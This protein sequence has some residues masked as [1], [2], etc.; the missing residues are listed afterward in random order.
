MK[1]NNI[2]LNKLNVFYQVV[3]LGGYAKASEHL[4]V[5]KSALSQSITSLETQIGVNLF[6]RRSKK[7]IPTREALVLF[8]SFDEHHKNLLNTIETVLCSKDSVSGQVRVG[9]YLEFAKKELSSFLASFLSENSDAQVKFKFESPSRLRELLEKNRLDL[10]FSIHPVKGVKGVSSERILK[11]E[12]VMICEKG[13]RSHFKNFE[14]FK[15]ARYIGYYNDH[16]VLKRW[17]GVHFS[18]RLRIFDVAVFAA[19]AE[20]VL[21]CVKEGIGIG[22]VPNYLVE[23]VSE[24]EILRPS[25]AKLE[26]Y[27]WLNYFTGQFSK[28]KHFCT[29]REDF[30][31]TCVFFEIKKV[32]IRALFSI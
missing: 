1:L 7:L 15:H 29:K 24:V 22:V 2:D 25:S 18:K 28:S 27:I 21:S 26:D 17:A 3:R 20:M 30:R 14:N 19:T 31:N 23:G 8:D 6:L 32:K 13:K 11:E 12:L 10:A 16:L 4:N 5:T 9:A